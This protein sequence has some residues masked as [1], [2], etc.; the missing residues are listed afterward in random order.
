MNNM[1]SKNIKIYVISLPEDQHRRDEM[2][3]RFGSIYDE[4]IIIEGIRLRDET[5]LV[6]LYGQKTYD[7]ALTIAELGCAL[8]HVTALEHFLRSEASYALILEDDAIGS[9]TEIIDI[10]N[11]I[12]NL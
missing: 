5:T 2:R 6:D 1:I 11:T 7:P 8:S 12:N 10:Y 9:E 4:F 3:K